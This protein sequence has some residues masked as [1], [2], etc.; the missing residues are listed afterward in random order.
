MGLRFGVVGFG[1]IFMVCGLGFRVEGFG[2]VSKAFWGL[3]GFRDQGVWITGQVSELTPE[4]RFP[5]GLA[6]LRV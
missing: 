2:S 5:Q 1:V 4:G 6:G 3:A